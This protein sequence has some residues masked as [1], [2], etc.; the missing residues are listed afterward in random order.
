M[1]EP[2]TLPETKPPHTV[3]GKQQLL[4]MP[5]SS[6]LRYRMAS[7]EGGFGAL[8]YKLQVPTPGATLEGA[9]CVWVTSVDGGVGG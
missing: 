9:A 2:C 7:G 3:D 4:T 5:L 8:K 1:A 6:P